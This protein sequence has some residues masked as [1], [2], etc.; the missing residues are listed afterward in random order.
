MAD[1]PNLEERVTGNEARVGA[2]EERQ[3]DICRRLD[4]LEAKRTP[5]PPAVFAH[6]L[7]PPGAAQDA[8]FATTPEVAAQLAKDYPRKK[9]KA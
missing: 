4:A 2:V 3:D 6:P 5:K 1:K 7:R 8:K 9:E